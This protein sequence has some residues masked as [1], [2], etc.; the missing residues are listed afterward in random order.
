MAAGARSLALIV[1]TVIAGFACG[2]GDG[3]S[4]PDARPTTDAAT[5]ADAAPMADADPLAPDA[6]DGADAMACANP[7]TQA[8][9]GA[10]LEA[11]STGGE[12]IVTPCAFG[13]GPDPTTAVDRCNECSPSTTACQGDAVV[14]C[15]ADGVATAMTS[16]PMGCNDAATPDPACYVLEPTN[17]P[18]DTCDTG[19]GDDVTLPATTPSVAF[20]TDNA[21]ACDAV[22][23]QAGPEICVV[24][25][26]TF[27]IESGV[28][29]EVSGSRALAIVT[30]TAMTI[31]G[32]IDASAALSEPGP[33]A[34]DVG[35]GTS[36][37]ASIH[38]GGGAGHGVAGA[39][40]GIGPVANPVAGSAG[41][42]YNTAEISPLQG[43]SSGGRGRGG[44]GGGAVQ[45]VSCGTLTL[46][47]TVHVGGGGGRGGQGVVVEDPFQGGGG[48]GSGGAVLIEAAVV[49]GSNAV[50]AANGGGGGAG[51]LA[52][53]D[54][55][56]G[57][58][59]ADGA[60]ATAGDQIAPGA[61]PVFWEG[62]G[63][64]GGAGA[65][66]ATT[67]QNPSAFGAG[68]GGGGGAVGRIR[69]NVRPGTTPDLTT[70]T[71]SPAASAGEA[72]RH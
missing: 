20:D 44:G 45:L 38:G 26:N 54:V 61:T 59:G 1:Y 43:G 65:T 41:S 47:G 5:A 63:G 21:A 60:D 71:T 67:G 18:A 28:T 40:G 66:A 17:L 32:V 56:E 70:P 53:D 6:G 24:R 37:N 34:V 42:A 68:A 52:G 36:G 23:S 69:I 19:G 31:D 15:D 10:N 57:P 7:G 48:G 27:T 12:L 22:I 72:A 33:G 14:V 9:N 55:Q 30:S 16:C 46:N 51:G 58:D 3:D 2:G 35:D 11:C 25:A 50:L 29:V 4:R 49:D 62:G 39:A 64:S 8:C 13:C